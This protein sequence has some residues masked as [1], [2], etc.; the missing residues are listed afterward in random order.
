M[1]DF[2]ARKQI[3]YSCGKRRNSSRMRKG[4]GLSLLTII[5]F[6]VTLLTRA[7]EPEETFE[8]S[9]IFFT[10]SIIRRGLS[11]CLMTLGQDAFI[12]LL[13]FVS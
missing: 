9:P 7:L 6:G 1:L 4:K 5:D 8:A 13:R 10:F 3:G 2:I 11:C 12:S